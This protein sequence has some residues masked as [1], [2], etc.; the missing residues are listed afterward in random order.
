MTT[1]AIINLSQ[2]TRL[3][4]LLMSHILCMS[5]SFFFSFAYISGSSTFIRI[6][7]YHGW[8]KNRSTIRLW[9]RKIVYICKK[10]M[11]LFYIRLRSTR[12]GRVYS[13]FEFLKRVKWKMEIKKWAFSLRNVSTSELSDSQASCLTVY[14]R[15]RTF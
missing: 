1:T 12:S 11:F 15:E 13:R 9:S 14:H 10:G 5:R 4:R 6:K 7:V 8:I 2:H 3:N